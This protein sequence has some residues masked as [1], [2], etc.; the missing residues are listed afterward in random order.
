[1]SQ[2]YEVII[3]GGGPAGL[4]AGIYCA[5]ARMKSLLL[6]DISLAS[7]V[8]LT[9]RIENY[10]GF[11]EGVSSIPL[12]EKF[13]EQASNV[14]LEFAPGKVEKIEQEE[15]QEGNLA[16][17]WKTTV[18]NKVYHALSL[19]VATGAG[20]KK[21]G[22]PGEERLTGKGVS[23]CA[24]CDATF[25]K[26]KDVAVLGGGDTA[27]Q[28]ALYLA[29][30]ASRVILVHRRSRLRATK[31]LQERIMVNEKIEFSWDSLA[32]EILGRGMVEGIRV[33]NAK[34]KKEKRIPCQGVFIF[35]GYLP[36]TA[37]LGGILSMDESGYIITDENM[38]TSRE[39]V[40]ACGD[41]RK[42]ILRQ[43]VTA[44]GEGATAAFSSQQYVE[45]LKGVAYK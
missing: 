15:K 33:E 31:I 29:K 37:F 41:C 2:I 9:E 13:K 5:R 22:L 38:S 40:F 11:P 1:M 23:Y 28:E 14:G 45:K 42:K 16:R 30:F 25:F 12:M 39:G 21:L 3:I 4:T 26:G 6:E 32:K 18:D 34:T 7:Q 35:A 27:V 36:N 10:P 20:P 19:I 24:I 44:C 17:V 43:V 8:L